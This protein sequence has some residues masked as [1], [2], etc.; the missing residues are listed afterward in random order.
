MEIP[1]IAEMKISSL[2]IA[3]VT[4][5]VEERLLAPVIGNANVVSGLVKLGIAFGIPK[6]SKAEWVSSIALG[7]AVD[8]VEDLVT[9]FTGGQGVV[10]GVLSNLGGAL[11]GGGQQAI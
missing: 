2:F 7:F 9:S 6:L 10:G 3:G 4:K 1:K 11:G 8:G 5:S